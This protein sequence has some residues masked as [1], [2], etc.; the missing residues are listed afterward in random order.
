MVALPS[1]VFFARSTRRLRRILSMLMDRSPAVR[2]GSAVFAWPAAGGAPRPEA[3]CPQA[4][5]SETA[6][7]P[8]Q[9]ARTRSHDLRLRAIGRIPHGWPKAAERPNARREVYEEAAEAVHVAIPSRA[10][11]GA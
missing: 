7:Q 11:S 3:A 1:T 4:E 2:S 9:A 8:T 5:G 10:R 6:T